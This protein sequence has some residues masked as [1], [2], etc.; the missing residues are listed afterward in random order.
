MAFWTIIE[1]KTILIQCLILTLIILSVIPLFGAIINKIITSILAF[2][3]GLC[4]HSGRALVFFM[5]RITFPGVIYHELSHALWAFLMGAKV[6]KVSLYRQEGDHLGYVSYVPRGNLLLR[7][8]QLALASCAPV[9]MGLL[10]EAGIIYLF[11]NATLHP[12]LYVLLAYIFIA[13]LVH[14]D[15]SLQDVKGYLKGMP[16]CFL[17]VFVIVLIIL[18]I[19]GPLPIPVLTFARP[20]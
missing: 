13:I 18:C 2:L 8:L 5:N 10:A 12:V 15:M 1:M 19:K 17:L 16:I 6:E 20:S 14:I 3:L 7:S 9:F 11:L 4:D